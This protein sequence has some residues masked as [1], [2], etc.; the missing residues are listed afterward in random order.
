MGVRT[1][2]QKETAMSQQQYQRQIERET[3]SSDQLATRPARERERHAILR[4]EPSPE[5]K[6]RR[7]R[8]T[9]ANSAP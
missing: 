3:L 9:P 4:E 1:N 6:R 5:A 7:E 2:K 8:N